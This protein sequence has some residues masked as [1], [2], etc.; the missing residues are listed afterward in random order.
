MK[1][2]EIKMMR[3]ES[4]EKYNKEYKW[5]IYRG[6]KFYFYILCQF[7]LLIERKKGQLVGFFGVY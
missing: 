7:Y 4:C 2:K 5:F 3:E 1:V 6:F